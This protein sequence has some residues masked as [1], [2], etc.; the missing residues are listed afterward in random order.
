M[1]ICNPIEDII[2]LARRVDNIKFVYYRR[3]ANEMVDKIAKKTLIIV[4]KMLLVVINLSSLFFKL[5]KW[6]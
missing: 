5:K 6:K 4:N 3:S 2:M 1:Q